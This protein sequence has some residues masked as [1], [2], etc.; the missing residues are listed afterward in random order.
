MGRCVSVLMP[1]IMSHALVPLAAAAVLGRARMTPSVVIAG[2]VL[3]MLP[4][5][6]TISFL[7]GIDY[8]DQFGHRGASHSFAAAG[9]FAALVMAAIPAARTVLYAAFLFVSCASHGLL[10]TLTNG[11]LGAA[12]LWP[13]SDIRFHAGVTPIAVSPI[14]GAFFSG[15]GLRVL[16]SEAAWIWLPCG[17]ATV[18]AYFARLAKRRRSEAPS[19]H[20]EKGQ[21]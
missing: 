13:V 20:H 12:L 9:F 10:D 4:D 14:G 11:G 2:A 1:T 17:V 16:M 15:R 19:Q 21:S 6:D 5:A 18:L 3:A 7:M 8:A